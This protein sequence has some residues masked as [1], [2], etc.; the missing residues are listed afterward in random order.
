MLMWDRLNILRCLKAS[1]PRSIEF[2]NKIDCIFQYPGR[3]LSCKRSFSISSPPRERTGPA[4]TAGGSFVLISIVQ[5]TRLEQVGLDKR[6]HER[7]EGPVVT[8]NTGQGM[9]GHDDRPHQNACVGC[10][11]PF[12]CDCKGIVG[13]PGAVGYPGFPGAQGVPGEDGPPGRPGPRGEKGRLG[14]YGDIGPRGVRGLLGSEGPVGPVGLDG[15]NGT[16]GAKGP[17]GMDGPPGD[18]GFPGRQGLIGMKG[19][20][21]ENGVNSPGIRGDRGEPGQ[22]GDDARTL[23][24]IISPHPPMTL[25]FQAMLTKHSTKIY[26]FTICR[27]H[28]I[29]RP[30]SRISS[31]YGSSRSQK[32][33]R[34]ARKFL[35]VRPLGSK[36]RN[37]PQFRSLRLAKAK[38]TPPVPAP[39]QFFPRSPITHHSYQNVP[40]PKNTE[41]SKTTGDT[42]D[43]SANNSEKKPEIAESSKE[44]S[45]SSKEKEAATP[46]AEKAQQT[47]IQSTL[48]AQVPSIPM[49]VVPSTSSNYS[50][51]QS[52]PSLSPALLGPKPYPMAL[53]VTSLVTPTSSTTPTTTID[54]K[55]YPV[56]RTP[57]ITSYPVRTPKPVLTYST[58][59]VTTPLVKRPSNA[60]ISAQL[61]ARFAPGT[62]AS[63]S[64]VKESPPSYS[65]ASTLI[66]A[67]KPQRTSLASKSATSSPQKDEPTPSSPRLIKP[68]T[69]PMTPLVHPKPLRSDSVK[70]S[71]SP[72]VALLTP[73]ASS[74]LKRRNSTVEVPILERRSQSD[75]EEPKVCK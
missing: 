14:D 12:T 61:L 29:S 70:E 21:G 26:H 39:R 47:T 27:I 48:Y 52:R 66:L 67:R 55:R 40:P 45:N 38:N 54:T 17:R 53:S 2:K 4:S 34:P 18:Y 68:T 10:S 65:R 50:I 15:C 24:R 74:S 57:S 33:A 36:P 44:T 49:P 25:C 20:P 7:A 5:V 28:K 56:S 30:P 72:I 19:D 43:E 31:G 59:T 42:A 23:Q 11:N 46:V 37:W 35:T 64:T 1:P 62:S 60:S 75:T 8:N 22:P 13:P 63:P 41:I 9:K 73:T 69:L 58:H 71:G 32:I 16:D 51:L 3:I 6:R